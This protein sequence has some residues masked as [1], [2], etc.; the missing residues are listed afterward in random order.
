MSTSTE[1]GMRP[2]IVP[3]PASARQVVGLVA[4]PEI[5]TRLRSKAFLIATVASVVIMVALWVILKLVSGSPSTLQVGVT[6]ST[7]S[8]GPQLVASASAVGAHVR[9]QTVTSDAAGRDA[10]REGKLDGMLVGDGQRVQ[11]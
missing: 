6:P 2:E 10:V 4:H 11:V 1:T 7:A 3:P 9:T 8:L 5:T